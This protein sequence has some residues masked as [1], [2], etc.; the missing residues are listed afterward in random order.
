VLKWYLPNFK[1]IQFSD[2]VFFSPRSALLCDLPRPLFKSGAGTQILHGLTLV[3]QVVV[4]V[5]PFVETLLVPRNWPHGLS[6][7]ACRKAPTFFFRRGWSSAIVAL[8]IWRL[9][10]EDIYHPKKADKSTHT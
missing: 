2:I 8:R 10:D 9:R 5:G 1:N 7:F 4:A 3:R 6:Q